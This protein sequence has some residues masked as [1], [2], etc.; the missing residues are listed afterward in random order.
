LKLNK[1]MVRAIELGQR[2]KGSTSPNPPVG[3]VI[4]KNERIISEGWTNPPGGEHAEA[5]AI[6]LAGENANNSTLYSTLEPCNHQGRTGPCT[7]AII[8]SGIKRVCIGIKDPNPLV[9]GGGVPYLEKAGIQV[10]VDNAS[11]DAKNLIE[12]FTKYSKTGMPFVTA[13]FAM[14]LDGKIATRTGDSKWITSDNSRQLAHEYR[15]QSDA[16]VVGINTVMNDNPQLTARGPD[17]EPLPVQPSRVV[18][19]SKGRFPASARMLKEP[20]D[21]IIATT[22]FSS[23]QPMD[24]AKILV[25]KEINGLLNMESLLLELAEMGIINIMVEGGGTLLGALFD[26]HL[27]DKVLA[28]IAPV[29]IGGRTAISPVEGLGIDNMRSAL[30]LKQVKIEPLGDEIV[31]IGYC[32]EDSNTNYDEPQ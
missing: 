11:E 21:T 17:G 15:R 26:A 18:V 5:M 31:L 12:A 10:F 19:D 22:K 3:A 23:I 2:A 16:L 6:R 9:I 24:K 30:R 13:K 14:S 1:Y 29:I 32:I 7:D 8:M 4:V 27:V 25:S 28:F 20:G